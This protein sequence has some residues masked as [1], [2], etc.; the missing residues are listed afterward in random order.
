VKDDPVAA[1]KPGKKGGAGAEAEGTEETYYDVIKKDMGGRVA[2]TK[3]AMDALDPALRVAM[4]GFRP[5]S[6][7][8]MRFTGGPC[9][10]DTIFLKS[11]A[12]K[13]S[14]AGMPCDLVPKSL[15]S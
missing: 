14:A 2:R 8:R 4:E 6:Y 9:D 7:L 12:T 1:S 11:K 13:P 5:G 10:L 3:A 15:N